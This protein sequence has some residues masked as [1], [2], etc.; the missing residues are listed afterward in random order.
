MKTQI[1]F[2]TSILLIIALFTC[3]NANNGSKKLMPAPHQLSYASATTNSSDQSTKD[4]A[5]ATMHKDNEPYLPQIEHEHDIDFCDFKHQEKRIFWKC[6]ANRAFAILYH[7]IIL[8][9]ILRESFAQIIRMI[10]H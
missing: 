6:V 7:I 5:K 8:M 4:E 3:I 10:E 1:I 2:R 9:P